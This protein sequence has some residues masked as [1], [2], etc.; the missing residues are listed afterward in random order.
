MQSLMPNQNAFA[1]ATEFDIFMATFKDSSERPQHLHQ[2][3]PSLRCDTLQAFSGSVF[4]FCPIRD[5]LE[6]YEM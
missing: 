6:G 5:E 1:Y 4:F 2:L 3:W